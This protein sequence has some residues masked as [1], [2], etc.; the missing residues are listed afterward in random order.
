MKNIFIIITLLF[1]TSCSDSNDENFLG[2]GL[3]LSTEVIDYYSTTSLSDS[4]IYFKVFSEYKYEGNKLIEVEDVVDSADRLGY[5]ISRII[6]KYTYVEDKIIRIDRYNNDS[7]LTNSDIFEYQNELIV[8]K[9]SKTIGLINNQNFEET[10]YYEYDNDSKLLKLIR[11]GSYPYEVEFEY[12]T[13][14]IIK[15]TILESNFSLENYEYE[16][17][18]KKNPLINVLGYEAILRTR[19]SV[20]FRDASLNNKKSYKRYINGVLTSETYYNNEY[21]GLGF[22]KKQTYQTSGHTLVKKYN[23]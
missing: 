13:Q 14:N 4:N 19:E 15:A 2:K 8:K 16:F 1:L 5:E 11:E 18:T 7:E 20:G 21:N 23:Y 12:N 10:T 22:L 17:D 6:T 3:L 9:T